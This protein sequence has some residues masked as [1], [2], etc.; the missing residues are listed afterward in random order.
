[1]RRTHAKG[2]AAANGKPRN[3]FAETRNYAILLLTRRIEAASCETRGENK[4]E[5]NFFIFFA[6]TH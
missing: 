3:L 5:R 4:G 1:M 6:L 2:I